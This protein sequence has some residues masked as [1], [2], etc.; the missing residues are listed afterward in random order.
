MQQTTQLIKEK[1]MEITDLYYGAYLLVRGNKLD[2]AH[3]KDEGY[4]KQV[5]FCFKGEDLL[6][7]AHEYISG[8]AK[9]NV[10]ELR[11]HINHLKRLTFEILNKD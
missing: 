9:A 4:K 7:S 6:K 10:N 2:D 3:L 8:R 1:T 11:G 5:V